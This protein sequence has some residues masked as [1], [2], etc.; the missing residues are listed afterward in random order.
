MARDDQPEHQMTDG[1]LLVVDDEVEIREI[2]GLYA[3]TLGMKVFEA[4][5]GEAALEILRTTA[6][7]VIVSDLMMPRMTGLGLLERLRQDGF[8]Q[9]FIFVTAYPSQ[10][11]TIQAL[12]LGAFDYLEKPFDPNALGVLLHEAMRVSRELKKLPDTVESLP[13]G[14]DG[15]AMLEIHKL[16]TLR[17]DLRDLPEAA[18]PKNRRLLDLFVSE[19]TPQL[20]FCEAAVQA[21]G[22]AE[23]R[24]FELGYLFRVMQGIGAAAGSIGA[25]KVKA[26]AQAAANFYTALRVKPRAF[27]PDYAEL[28]ARTNEMLRILVAE[29]GIAS[30]KGLIDDEAVTE[31]GQSLEDASKAVTGF[32]NYAAS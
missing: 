18:D 25:D 22:K 19:A 27:A 3:S 2:I 29:V 30:G 24:S 5:D 20:L 8:T 28:A 11:S 16:G 1:T 23:S 15:Q 4:S 21:L 6:V 26:L 13:S 10:D 9:P 7:D 31:L 17:Y 32:T 14:A 12:R